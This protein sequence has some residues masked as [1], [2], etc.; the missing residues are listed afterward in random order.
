MDSLSW[1]DAYGAVRT[2]IILVLISHRRQST[3]GTCSPPPSLCFLQQM[4]GLF[5]QRYISFLFLWCFSYFFLHQRAY[6]YFTENKAFHSIQDFLCNSGLQK[7]FSLHS[8]LA[9]LCTIFSAECNLL[10]LLMAS[11][12]LGSL[13]SRPLLLWL[14]P[15]CECCQMSRDYDFYR[16]IPTFG[17]H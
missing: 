4:F 12:F 3:N 5:S 1:L 17:I 2:Y 14:C 16:W 9:P 13:A 11:C 7:I 10:D 15:K 8:C 6:L